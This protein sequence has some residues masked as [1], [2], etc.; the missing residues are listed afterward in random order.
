MSNQLLKKGQ[1]GYENIFPRTY[2]DAIKDR[3]TG[4]SLQDI[5][6]NFNM[7]FLSYTGDVQTTRLGVI[8]S[9]RKRGL[10]ITYI[11]YDSILVTEWY[12]SNSIT[13]EE[14]QKSS[15][16]RKGTNSLVGDISITSDGY[17][18]INGQVTQ[19]K[20]QGERGITPLLRFSEN[21]KLEVSYDEG[22]TYNILGNITNY[23]RIQKYI[24]ANE[25]LPTLNIEEGTIYMKGPVYDENDTLN[26]YPIYRMWV[27]AYKEDTLGWQDNGEFQSILAGIVQEIGDNENVVMS[28]KAVS[29]ALDMLRSE[30]PVFQEST[31]E[32]IEEMIA[33][34]AWEEGVLYLA[35]EEEEEEEEEEV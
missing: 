29:T 15:N 13:D 32:E 22:K 12:S 8:P 26:E 2:L 17:W 28:Q 5:I 21:N 35:Y 24:G 16:W 33:N 10:W 4:V 27:Y 9:L 25:S 31:E 20:A 6:N 1:K 23:L 7:L 14:W 34:G 19:A 18:V 30:I 3:A 11:D